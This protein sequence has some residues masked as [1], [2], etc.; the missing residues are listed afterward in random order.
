[1]SK[2]ITKRHNSYRLIKGVVL[3]WQRGKI[4]EGHQVQV[5]EAD[6]SITGFRWKSPKDPVAGDQVTVILPEKGVSAKPDRALMILNETTGDTHREIN[7]HDPRGARTIMANMIIWLTIAAIIAV[8][9]INYAIP[10]QAKIII[11]AAAALM[12]W[13][14]AIA[15]YKLREDERAAQRKLDEEAVCSEIV[16][17]A[18]ESN[19]ESRKPRLDIEIDDLGNPIVS[20]SS[21]EDGKIHIEEGKSATG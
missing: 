13:R 5:I 10:E 18:W 9:L 21:A 1:M 15:T 6:N 8:V 16:M 4:G 3:G 14:I 17:N 20:N 19:T 2:I 11:L 7:A 12:V